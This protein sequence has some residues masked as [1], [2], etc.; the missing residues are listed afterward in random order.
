MH[1]QCCTAALHYI[2]RRCSAMQSNVS[3]QMNQI[4]EKL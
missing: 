4:I 2:I 3:L 1:Q